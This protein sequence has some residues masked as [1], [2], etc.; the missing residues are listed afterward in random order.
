LSVIRTGITTAHTLITCLITALYTVA[1]NP[2]IST[3]VTAVDT[4]VIQ[5]ITALRTVT[6]KPVIGTGITAAHTLVTCLITALHT[7]TELFVIRAGISTVPTGIGIFITRRTVT[8]LSI[9]RTGKRGDRAQHAVMGMGL[10]HHEITP[11]QTR[12]N[13]IVATGVDNGRDK[14]V[15]IVANPDAYLLAHFTT[16]Y[17]GKGEGVASINPVFE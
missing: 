12:G 16:A 10:N 17:R 7:V 4:L 1:V 9:I 14:T 8:E 3:G 6:V 11:D 2:V 5:F 13:G 15:P